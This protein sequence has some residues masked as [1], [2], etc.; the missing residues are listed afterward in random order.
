MG[1]YQGSNTLLPSC[2]ELVSRYYFE[3]I[4]LFIQRT[5]QHIFMYMYQRCTE[6][7]S[8]IQKPHFFKVH[9]GFVCM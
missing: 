8:V 7:I 2:L 4:M 3:R 5:G 1:T 9:F 6:H